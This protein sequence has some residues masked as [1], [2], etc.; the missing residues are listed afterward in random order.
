MGGGRQCLQSPVNNSDADP[1]DTWSCLSHD[2]R[3][4]IS[5]WKEDKMK[6]GK[7]VQFVSNNEEL[8][9]VTLDTEFTLGRVKFV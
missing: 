6:H 7:T 9:M 3:N 2:R 5:H 4:L 8:E 1:V